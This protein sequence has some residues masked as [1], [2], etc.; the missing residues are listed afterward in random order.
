[1]HEEVETFL[2][3]I[4]TKTGQPLRPEDSPVFTAINIGVSFA[5]A[6]KTVDTDN[7]GALSADFSVSPDK[8]ITATAALTTPIGEAIPPIK[9]WTAIANQSGGSTITI[10]E[11]EKKKSYSITIWYEATV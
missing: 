10:G 5:I 9:K 1:M 4:E 2:D 3:D 7:N 6:T 8:M 11:L